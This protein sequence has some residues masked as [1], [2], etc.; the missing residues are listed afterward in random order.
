MYTNH[1]LI[2]IFISRFILVQKNSSWS[3]WWKYIATSVDVRK[4]Q[5]QIFKKEPN[6]LLWCHRSKWF[7]QPIQLSPLHH[8]PLQVGSTGKIPWIIFKQSGND[9]FRNFLLRD[10]SSITSACFW[11]FFDP[12]THLISR[13]QRVFIT[14]INMTSADPHTHPLNFFMLFNK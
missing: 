3:S 9:N 7:Q 14:N 12:P 11:P 2:N 13:L 10:H 1:Y 8:L 4:F 6:L 5:Q